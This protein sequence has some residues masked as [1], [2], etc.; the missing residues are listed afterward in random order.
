M[1]KDH[2]VYIRMD[3]K[4]YEKI[5]KMAKERK[6]SV[7]KQIQYMLERHLRGDITDDGA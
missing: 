4:L 2:T 6:R 7:G 5:K 1:N 3:I